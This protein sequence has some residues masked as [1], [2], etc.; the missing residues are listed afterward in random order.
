MKIAAL[1][2]VLLYIVH[3]AALNNTT[4]STSFL[5]VSETSRLLYLVNDLRAEYGARPLKIDARFT[6]VAQDQS[7]YQAS[8]CVLSHYGANGEGL[9]TRVKMITGLFNL[10]LGENVAAG[11]TSVDAAFY[12][13][14]NSP[15]HFRNMVNPSFNAVGF[16][17]AYNYGCGFVRY[18]TQDFAGVP[19]IIAPAQPTTT[20]TKTMIKTTTT[21]STT[22]STTTQKP[23]TTK[24]ST[25][26]KSTT[27]PK[28][29][30]KSTSTTSPKSTSTTTKTSSK[31]TT[32]TVKIQ[33]TLGLWDFCTSS[34]QCTN[35]C[36]SNVYSDGIFKCTPNTN[37]CR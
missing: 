32:T 25:S 2:C 27:S 9:A 20:T 35:G 7:K 34:A 14:K 13:W 19:F 15:G 17:F 3:A 33:P 8:A 22:K 31:T 36:C 1:V 26:T 28:S 18:W 11:Y 4:N 37:Q 30:S 16:G 10:Y 21:K 23:T 24:S 5:S 29:T 12:G 6:A